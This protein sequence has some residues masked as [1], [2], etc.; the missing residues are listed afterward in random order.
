MNWNWV[1]FL[2]TLEAIAALWI[3]V[4]LVALSSGG[5]QAIEASRMT[6]WPA[7]PGRV[8]TS[9]SV[10]TAFRGRGLRYAPAARI[11]YEYEAGGSAHTSERV[12]VETRPVEAESAEGQRRLRDYPVG[13]EVTVYYDP[14]DPAMAVLERGRPGS[15]FVA[16]A[17]LIG[18]GLAVAAA[19][20]LL[21]KRPLAT[22][23]AGAA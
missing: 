21:R 2:Q 16:G 1:R 22:G 20:W 15:P 17:T 12:G 7:A 8:V 14:D 10:T 11:V 3:F 6:G 18:M 5:V 13:A 4:G 19:R 23:Q 9:E